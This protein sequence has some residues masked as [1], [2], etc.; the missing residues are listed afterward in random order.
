MTNEQHQ[1]NWNPARIAILRMLWDEGLST[2]AI[3]RCMQISK[4][5]VIGKVHRLQLPPRPSPIRPRQAGATA[6]KAALIKKALAVV[7]PERAPVIPPKPFVLAPPPTH[8]PEPA[9]VREPASTLEPA[10]IKTVVGEIQ[11]A[12]IPRRHHQRSCAW[13]L[14]HPGTTSFRYCGE[15]VVPAKPYCEQHCCR[16]YVR[17]A[18]QDAATA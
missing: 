17:Y 8:A 2:A 16:A 13:P 14:G 5:A 7:K 11:P 12:A 3:G 10:P 18:R 9:P 4:N 1:E 15:D 6:T